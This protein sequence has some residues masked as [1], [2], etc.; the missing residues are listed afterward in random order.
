MGFIIPAENSVLKFT[1]IESL[2]E[3]VC[4]NFHELLT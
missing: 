2:E 3:T 1:M 4:T